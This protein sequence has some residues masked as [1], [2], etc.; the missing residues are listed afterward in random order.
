MTRLER[1]DDGRKGRFIIYE[2]DVFAGEMT[3]SWAGNERFIISHTGVEEEFSGKGYGRQLVMEAV[4][5]ARREEVKILPLC[6]YAKKVFEKNSGI[7]DVR[8]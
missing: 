5:F 6:P 4:E 3:Y 8:F 2:D 7:Q 1:E